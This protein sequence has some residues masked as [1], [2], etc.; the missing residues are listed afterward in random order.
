MCKLL[1]AIAVSSVA[2]LAADP[3]LLILHKGASSLGFY[4]PAGQ[5][6]D[7]V[8]VGKH[9]HE[10]VLS[11]D[12]RFAYTSDNGTMRIE[13][14]GT[15]GNTVSI[16]DLAAR[17]KAG[18]ISLGGFRRPHGLDVDAAGGRLAVTTEL[19]DRLLLIDLK[20]NRVVKDFDTKGKT[21]HMVTLGPGAKWAYV[22]NSG[23]ANVSAVNL[24]TGDVVMIPCGERP[25]GSALSKDGR[26]VYIA[27]RESRSITVIDTAS[28]KAVGTIQTGNG[29]VRVRSTP[30]GK[31]L[32]YAAMHD[33]AVEFADTATRKVVGKVALPA[34]TGIV[35]LQLS[36]DGRYATASAEEDDTVY[37]ISVADRKVERTIKTAQGTGPDP[38]IWWR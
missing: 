15:G 22:S 21:S 18:E 27:N 33:R 30:D 20:S 5:L 11:P 35:S 4:T 36:R 12:G 19:P 8:D 6:V 2:A 31:M 16:V 23:S 34:K 38:A 3:V 7:S 32:V 24:Q 29:P 28:N 10:I 13:E 37:V 1:M 25:E 17:K 9:P 14:A 26:E